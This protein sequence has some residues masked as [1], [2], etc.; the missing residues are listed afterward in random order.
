[1]LP[2][3][4]T[5]IVSFLLANGYSDNAAAG[6]AGKYQES[7]GNPESEGM[8]GGGLIGFT[9]LGPAG[10]V[11]GNVAADLQTQLSGGAYLQPAVGVLPARAQL[12][13]YPGGRGGHLRHRFRAGGHPRR[14]QPGGLRRGSRRSLR[15]LGPAARLVFSPPPGDPPPRR[16][17]PSP[18]FPP[19]P[20]GRA[21]QPRPPGP[22]FPRARAFP[23]RRAPR[24]PT[25]RPD[26]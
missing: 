12:G 24:G 14:R 23:S 13:R 17:S 22:G 8:G 11:T 10:Y 21:S 19:G 9:P 3:N 15:H 16:V 4:V 20:R 26:P 25:S 7:G 6:I 1:M 18:A 2:D 5:A